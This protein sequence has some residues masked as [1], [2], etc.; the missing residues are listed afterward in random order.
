MNYGHTV[1]FDE[2][3]ANAVFVTPTYSDREFEAENME[4]LVLGSTESWLMVYLNC[5]RVSGFRSRAS[6]TAQFLEAVWDAT[7]YDKANVYKHPNTGLEVVFD[8]VA[9]EDADVVYTVYEGNFWHDI[10]EYLAKWTQNNFVEN[11]ATAKMNEILGNLKG[12]SDAVNTLEQFDLDSLLEEKEEPYSEEDD[13]S[14]EEVAED[15]DE[16]Y[17]SE[18]EDEDEDDYSE[19]DEEDDYYEEDEEDTPNRAVEV[20]NAVEDLYKTKDN[21]GVRLVNGGYVGY[22]PDDQCENEEDLRNKIDEL[23]QKADF[24]SIVRLCFGNYNKDS[25]K[26]KMSDFLNDLEE[27]E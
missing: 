13:Y 15:E 16:N 8:N 1:A 11:E 23:I 20:A 24:A 14:D 18:E 3:N 21:A 2:G 6:K 22:I 19:E 26:D 12:I 10:R 4:D 27:E 5:K 7:G 25:E 9:Y 17:Y